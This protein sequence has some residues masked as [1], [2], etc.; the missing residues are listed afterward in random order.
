MI[1]CDIGYNQVATIR[2]QNLGDK[3]SMEYLREARAANTASMKHEFIYDTTDY[4]TY[5]MFV[6]PTPI[7]LA[8]RYD[9]AF[10]LDCTYK[11]NRFKVPL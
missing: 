2:R 10:I 1:P 8:N 4:M 3:S 7:E 5:L 9:R 6:Y 11:T